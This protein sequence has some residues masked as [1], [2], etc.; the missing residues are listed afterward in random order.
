[1]R[2][3]H[4]LSLI[5]IPSTSALFFIIY[6]F[7]NQINEFL[8]WENAQ[9]PLLIVVILVDTLGGVLVPFL[10]IEKNN[11]IKNETKLQVNQS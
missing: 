3:S 5:I 6:Y 7:Q 1:M 4:K 11:K 9:N 10:F 8:N 2:L